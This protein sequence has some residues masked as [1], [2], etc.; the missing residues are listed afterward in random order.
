MKYRINF[1]FLPLSLALL[2]LLG[3]SLTGCKES[4]FQKKVG[5]IVPIEHKAMDQITTGFIETLHKQYRVPVKIKIDNAQ[6]DI[7]LERAIIAQMKNENYDLIVP[8]GTDATEMTAAMIAKQPIISLAA[9]YSDEDRKAHKPCNIAIVHD[10]ISTER[11]IQFIHAVYPTLTYLVLIH[12]PA[13][14]IYPEVSAA[15]LAGTKVGITIKAMMVP[16]LH[17]LYSTANNI[18]ANAEGIFVL[19]DHLIVSGISTLSY[20]AEKRKIPLITA[21]QGSVEEGAAFALGVPEREIGVAGGK[22]ASAILSGKDACQLP[23]V[24]MGN[25]TVFINKGSV[26]KENLSLNA[27]KGAAKSN[28]YGILLIN[29]AK[30]EIAP[31]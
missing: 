4:T 3:L 20:I 19:K 16:T 7:N 25:L 11:L 27:I 29:N 6:G 5:I 8:I 21:D 31:K 1:F 10:E 13:D 12:S 22:L 23:I 24:E 30:G 26:A 17:E 9:T 15:I 14:K 2:S 18:P 28:H